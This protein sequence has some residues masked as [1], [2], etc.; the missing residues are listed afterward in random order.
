MDNTSVEPHYWYVKLG[1]TKKIFSV[2]QTSMAIDYY[3]GE[4]TEQ[5]SDEAQSV[6][7]AFVQNVDAFATEFYFAVRNYDLDRDNA[8]LNNILAVFTGARVKF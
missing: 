5:E 1:Y 3:S 2:G 7:F 6:S 4:E 8:D